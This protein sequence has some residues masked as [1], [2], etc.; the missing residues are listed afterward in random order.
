VVPELY[1]EGHIYC[2]F[3]TVLLRLYCS[4]RPLQA[5][6]KQSHLLW[7]Y[8]SY[9][10]LWA[11]CKQS[12]LLWLY[13]SFIAT[14]LQLPYPYE[15]EVNSHIYW[16]FNVALLQLYCSLHLRSHLHIRRSVLQLIVSLLCLYCS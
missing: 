13:C 12:H 14:L 8:C 4:Y 16:D 2:D 3:V 6:S 1:V 10:P 11:W 7:L 9:H 15:P 5:L